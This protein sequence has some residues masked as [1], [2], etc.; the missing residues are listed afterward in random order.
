MS[1]RH[2]TR[3]EALSGHGLY[4]ICFFKQKFLSLVHHSSVGYCTVSGATGVSQ[5]PQ[6]DYVCIIITLLNIFPME[7]QDTDPVTSRLL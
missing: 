6:A 5:M 4:W 2:N 3:L 1:C 7:S